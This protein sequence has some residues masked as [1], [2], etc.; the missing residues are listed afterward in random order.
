MLWVLKRAVS[1]RRFFWAPKTIV[2][3][4]DGYNFFYNFT[5]NFFFIRRYVSL[6]RQNQLLEQKENIDKLQEQIHNK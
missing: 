2:K 1:M 5:L 6:E 4:I 3:K